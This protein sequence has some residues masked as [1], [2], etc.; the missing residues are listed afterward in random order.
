[1]YIFFYSCTYL[2]ANRKI[3]VVLSTRI[4][5]ER[6]ERYLI[7][8]NAKELGM[9]SADPL[10]SDEMIMFDRVGGLQYTFDNFTM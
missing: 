5:C 9:L 1:M 2:S 8:W 6:V 10:L 7:I 4:K 3:F